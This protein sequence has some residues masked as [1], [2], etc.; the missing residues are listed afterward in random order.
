MSWQCPY[1]VRLK[2]VNNGLVCKNAMKDGVDYN[3]QE[4]ALT[5]FCACQRYC[6]AERRAINSDGAKKC[7][8]YHSKA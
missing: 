2:C 8:E 1:G 5:V 6:P 4:N 7:Y 3:L